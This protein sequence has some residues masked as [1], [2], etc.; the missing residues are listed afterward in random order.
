M[1]YIV[2][3]CVCVFF[4]SCSIRRE[5][6]QINMIIIGLFEFVIIISFFLLENPSFFFI[7]LQ[8]SVLEKHCRHFQVLYYYFSS[9]TLND[10]K[11]SVLIFDFFFPIFYFRFSFLNFFYFSI[12]IL[13]ISKSNTNTN[14]M[15]ILSYCMS[16]I[17]F[18]Q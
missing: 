16:I 13:K 15:N 9:D 5:W 2:D 8:Y 4:I 10:S 12:F 1:Y 7:K 11:L 6:N 3:A 17:Q 14:T 18:I